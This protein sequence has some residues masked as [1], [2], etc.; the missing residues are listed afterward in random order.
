MRD[1][2]YQTLPAPGHGVAHHYGAGVKLLSQPW[3]MSLLTELCRPE[4]TQ[5]R[6]NQLLT[7][8]FDWML[9]EIVGRE[10]TK[11]RVRRSTRMP[12]GVYEGEI[13]DPTQGVVVAAMA[14][15]GIP[16]A[17][18]FYD[19]LN[20][21]LDPSGV[22]QDH[23][24]MAR[25]TDSSGHVVGVDVSGSKLGGGVQDATLLIPDPMG[26]TGGSIVETLRIYRDQVQGTPRRLVCAHLIVTPEYLKRVLGEFPDARIYAVRLD[27]GLSSPQ[28]L[29][30]APGKLWDQEK[31]LDD[32]DYIVPGAGGLGELMNNAWV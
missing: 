7:M 32:H 31:G 9:P 2:Q 21:L 13:V 16:P 27:R 3:A 8:L 14:R 22:R 10:L 20:Q 6:F 25:K 15:G 24:F 1:S 12:Q 11:R 17:Q 18:R 19:G 29:A 4:T 30:A 26:A 28:A 23:L 5:P